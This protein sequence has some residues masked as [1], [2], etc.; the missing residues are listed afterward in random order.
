MF[1][2]QGHPVRRE[3]SPDGRMPPGSRVG[4]GGTALVSKVIDIK[5]LVQCLAQ[6]SQIA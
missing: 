4:R 3:T 2:Y 5:L 6:S 1:E